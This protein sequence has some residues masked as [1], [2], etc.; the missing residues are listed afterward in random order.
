MNISLSQM[1]IILLQ[2]FL[3]IFFFLFSFFL[4]FV[5]SVYCNSFCIERTTWTSLSNT[6]WITFSLDWLL[7]IQ[8]FFYVISIK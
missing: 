8:V 4:D 1:E 3:T 7:G 5:K 6:K 2:H